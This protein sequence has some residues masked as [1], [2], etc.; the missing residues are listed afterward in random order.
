MG[1]EDDPFDASLN[2]P[3]VVERGSHSLRELY[4]ACPDYPT[5]PEESVYLFEYFRRC[6]MSRL[7]TLE[8]TAHINI[9]LD[10]RSPKLERLSI[11]QDRSDLDEYNSRTEPGGPGHRYFGQ[12]DD[13][14]ARLGYCYPSLTDLDLKMSLSDDNIAHLQNLPLRKLRLRDATELTDACLPHLA[15]IRDLEV[16]DLTG[17]SVG[18][19]AQEA[20]LGLE[21]RAAER[22]ARAAST[23][24]RI[25][26]VQEAA[27]AAEAAEQ[28]P[29]RYDADEMRALRSS[30]LAAAPPKPLPRVAGFVV[31]S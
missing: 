16:C 19:A 23:L 31:E 17:T 10:G 7:H 20:A 26:A 3:F 28:P 6:V 24:G 4:A 29:R 21:A 14:F 11:V 5:T 15:A 9:P 22:R 13:R 25:R 12:D 1:H 18:R 27:A 2:G 30:P 8:M